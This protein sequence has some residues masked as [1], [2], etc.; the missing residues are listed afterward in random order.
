M[1]DATAGSHDAPTAGYSLQEAAASLGI[2][3]NTLRRRIAAGLVRAEQVERP[4]G[5]VWRVYLDGRHPPTQPTSDPTD[6]EHPGSLPRP[7]APLAQ[8][9][10]LAALI[11]A[12]LAP[13]VAPLLA[14]QAALRQT[15]ERQADQLVGQAETI[16]RQGAELEAEQRAREQ[17]VIE[18]APAEVSR[19]RN[20]R[21]LR[22]ALAV[23]ATLAIAGVLAPVWIR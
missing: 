20:T 17:F 22:I 16:G 10:A 8:A 19:R 2:G 13:I 12:T 9:E 6:R 23:A 4:Q 3:I 5:Y 1:Q 7:P 18:R 14:E 21:R 15:V 11:Q